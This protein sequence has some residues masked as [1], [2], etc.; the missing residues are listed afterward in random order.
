[1]RPSLPTLAPTLVEPDSDPSTS[2]FTRGRPTSRGASTK[3]RS[4]GGKQSSDGTPPGQLTIEV[5]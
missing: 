3:P 4:G 2:T 5:A 1:V